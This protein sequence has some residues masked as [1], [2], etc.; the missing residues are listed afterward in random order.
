MSIV[1]VTT[2]TFLR[3]DDLREVSQTT[4]VPEQ[5]LSGVSLGGVLSLLVSSSGVEMSLNDKSGT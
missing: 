2:E 4:P 3:R 5:P 1:K